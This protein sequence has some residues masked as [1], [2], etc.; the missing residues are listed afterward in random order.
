MCIRDR[1]F[2]SRF[3][4]WL[5]FWPNPKMIT[6]NT[7]PSGAAAGYMYTVDPNKKDLNRI[8]DNINGLV[9]L[10]S[11]NGKLVLYSNSG[12]ALSL[13]NMDSRESSS[14]GLSTV[15]E[16]CTW[17]KISDTIYC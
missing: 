11:P 12:P 8:L 10:T 5:S 2:D 17:N 1:V 14:L 16:K 15:A 7:K 4:E 13:Y 6:L 3:T 9:T